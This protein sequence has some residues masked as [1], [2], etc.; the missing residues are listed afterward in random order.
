[1]GKIERKLGNIS[2]RRIEC[3]ESRVNPSRER[4]ASWTGRAVV[5]AGVDG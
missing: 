2:P 4:E 1:M 5:N 3:R